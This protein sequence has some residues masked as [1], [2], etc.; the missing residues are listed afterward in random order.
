MVRKRSTVVRS[1]TRDNSIYKSP[2][3]SR[4]PPLFFFLS[5][6]LFINV[7]FLP[8]ETTSSAIFLLCY[9]AHRLVK[10]FNFLSFKFLLLNA[11]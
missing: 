1:S 2:A 9:S 7:P 11:L 8:S 4:F 6:S 3:S 10:V 5:L